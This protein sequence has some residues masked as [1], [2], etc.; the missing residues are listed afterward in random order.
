MTTA[1]LHTLTGAYALHAL[2]GDE[3]HAFE[4]HLGDCDVCAQEVRELSATA[5][6]LGLASAAPVRPAVKDEV[7]RRIGG[8]RQEPPV[9]PPE[10]DSRDDRTG[11][12]RR[13]AG[14]RA[15]WALAACVAV[16]A[17]LGG[18]AVWQH[19][20]VRDTRQQVRQAERRSEALAAVL[21]APDA[22]SR[23]VKL[24]GGATGTVVV[25]E[26]QDR[27]AFLADGL[28]APPEGKV[29]QLWFDDGGGT[30]R[31][32]GVMPRASVQAVLLRGPVRHASGMGITVEPAG[33]SA[34]PTS[35]PLALLDLPV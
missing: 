10:S 21:A 11:V 35:A 26:R 7:L 28:A 23:G 14:G 29:Y 17:G 15:R 18:I 8:V 3:R 1:E 24:A 27:A 5:A 13:V 19:E 31:S 2:S 9:T 34:E 16:T 25:S 32:A 33:G 12:A 22:R 6:R 20:Q 4:H 30:M